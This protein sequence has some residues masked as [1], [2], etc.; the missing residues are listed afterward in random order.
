ME[1]TIKLLEESDLQ[2]LYQFEME[3]RVFFEELGFGRS[4][5]YYDI[6][7]FKQIIKELVENQK[8]DL[9]YMYLIRDAAENIVGRI[10][11]TDMIRGNMNKAEIGYRMGKV[12][13]G[14]GYAT[15][16]VGLI[17]EKAATEHKLHR[18]EAGTSVQNIGSQVALVKN[19]FQFTGRLRQYIFINGEWQDSITFEKII[20]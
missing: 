17:L 12:H 10:N 8:K 5:S 9:A 18:I 2:E 7:Q 13:Q 14:K 6:H 15:K 16:A 19:G 4:E 3:N 1:I 20:Q 11:L